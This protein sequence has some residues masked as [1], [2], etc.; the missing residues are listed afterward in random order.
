MHLATYAVVYQTLEWMGSMLGWTAGPSAENR[1]AGLLLECSYMALSGFIAE[2]LCE[3]GQ[4]PWERLHT[5]TV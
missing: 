3:F 1:S 2:A 5:A 4:S